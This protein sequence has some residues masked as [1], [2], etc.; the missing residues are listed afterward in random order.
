MVAIISA[1]TLA[2]LVCGVLYVGLRQLRRHLKPKDYGFHVYASHRHGGRHIG[3]A[4]LGTAL[5]W[6]PAPELARWIPDFEAVEG[7]ID[8][9]I[10]R[11]GVARMGRRVARSELREHFP[12]LCCEGLRHAL[13]LSNYV[14]QGARRT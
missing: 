11:G 2:A 10:Q 1:L 7:G 5:P 13:A 14:A 8:S 9:L 12:F 3:L 4:R 6:I